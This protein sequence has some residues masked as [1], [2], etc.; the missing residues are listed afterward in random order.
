[1]DCALLFLETLLI[2]IKNAYTSQDVAKSTE[3]KDEPKLEADDKPSKK[4]KKE[5]T[6]QPSSSTPPPFP[7]SAEI[8]QQT[9]QATIKLII[10]YSTVYV[11]NVSSTLK[12]KLRTTDNTIPGAVRLATQLLRVSYPSVSQ[13]KTLLEVS[14]IALTLI[15]RNWD[16]KT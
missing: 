13:L 11:D 15:L 5:D 14:R 3:N 12:T 9:L 16:T 6:E 10:E 8:L 7:L 4:R 2:K 1:M